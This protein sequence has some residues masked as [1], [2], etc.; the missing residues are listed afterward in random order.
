MQPWMID[1]VLTL[2]MLGMAYALY[3][4]GLWG[5]TLVFFNVLFASLIALNFYE[6]L[7]A[8]LA[9]NVS[10][11]ANLADV[12]CLGVLFLVTLILFKVCTDSMAPTL[13]RF[14]GL[15]DQIGRLVFALAG[16]ALTMAF[17]LVL[18]QTA[19]V[20]RKIFGVIDYKAAPPYGLGL[21]HKLL[22]FFQWT[23]GYIFPSGGDYSDPEFG[24]ANVF[25][26]RGSWLI[27][28][29]NARPF[30]SSGEGM[31]PYQ[32]GGGTAGGQA[33]P[34]GGEEGMPPAG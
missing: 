30:P 13:V 27:D 4:E 15:V 34:E 21:D 19:P 3:S 32:E 23:T 31:V 29:Q 20:H 16:S 18:L 28:H 5:A 22:A 7:A 24:N 26:R 14:P 8:L 33:A 2:L 9:K 12:L 6:P 11:V 25:D 10:A 17:L 1:A